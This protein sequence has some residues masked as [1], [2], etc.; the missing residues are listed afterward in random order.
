MITMVAK[1]RP[2]CSA[3]TW[4]GGEIEAALGPRRRFDMLMARTTWMAQATKKA[5][6][7][8]GCP[9]AANQAR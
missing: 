2:V 4:L 5:P 8:S 6:T 1:S 7:L 9:C 3:A